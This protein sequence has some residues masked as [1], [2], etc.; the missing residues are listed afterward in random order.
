M[1]YY[2]KSIVWDHNLS[3]RCVVAE[4]AVVEVV[5]VAGGVVVDV[6][7]V[8]VVVVVDVDVVGSFGKN[9]V[10]GGIHLIW[11]REARYGKVDG[12]QGRLQRSKLMGVADDQDK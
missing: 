10:A 7:V 6:V 4:A 5:M 11:Y 12:S 9:R 2:L 8:V 3:H 1:L